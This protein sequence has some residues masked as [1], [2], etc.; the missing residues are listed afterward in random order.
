MGLRLA[1]TVDRH[2]AASPP[3]GWYLTEIARKGDCGTPARLR[4]G[5]D[6]I[7]GYVAAIV[8]REGKLLL[9]INR[10]ELHGF[11]A[12]SLAMP[13]V[14]V[15]LLGEHLASSGMT[16]KRIFKL[17]CFKP[18]DAMPVGSEEIIN[19]GIARRFH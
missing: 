14:D 12:T 8:Y 5:A 18:R 6:A 9:F 7:F 19:A 2:L 15:A 3:F 16:P 17:P 10:G 1:R 4:L 11:S 13:V